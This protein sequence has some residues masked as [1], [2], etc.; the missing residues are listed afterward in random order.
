[1]PTRRSGSNF[2]PTRPPCELRIDQSLR[3]DRL[4]KAATFLCVAAIA[5]WPGFRRCAGDANGWCSRCLIETLGQF[6]H[7]LVAAGA[8]VIDNSAH[9]LFDLRVRETRRR[10]RLGN[11]AVE[12]R[13]GRNAGSSCELSRHVIKR[14]RKSRSSIYSHSIVLGG[15]LVMSRPTRFTPFTSLMMRVASFSKSS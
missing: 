11:G 1:M 8:H 2:S 14:R 5:R 15:L 9:S 12:I 10:T 4:A 13:S 7:G 6:H 3:S